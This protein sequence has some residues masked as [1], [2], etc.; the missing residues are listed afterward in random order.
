M[1]Y[2]GTA[3][4]PPLITADFFEGRAYGVSLGRFSSQFNRRAF[5]VWFGGFLHDHVGNY[6]PF[7]INRNRLR[8]LCLLQYLGLQLLGRSGLYQ[9][10]GFQVQ[11]ES[12]LLKS[13]RA[14]CLLSSNRYLPRLG[15][16]KHLV[17]ALAGRRAETLSFR[18]GDI[19][20]PAAL[21]TPGLMV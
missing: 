5:G 2:A 20:T 6:I 1:G 7:F 19:P 15:H 21:Q 4:L 13:N 18:G 10:K 14:L 17:E 3:V 16:G 8:S 12:D 9:E 11:T